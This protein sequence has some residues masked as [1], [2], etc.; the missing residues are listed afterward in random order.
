MR[1]KRAYALKMMAFG[2]NYIVCLHQHKYHIPITDSKIDLMNVVDAHITL[3]MVQKY[4]LDSLCFAT[5]VLRPFFQQGINM[6]GGAGPIDSALH[7][8]KE[9]IQENLRAQLLQQH[10]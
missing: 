5:D 3:P 7:L 9:Q 10:L 2:V 8:E 1:A 4:I 6:E